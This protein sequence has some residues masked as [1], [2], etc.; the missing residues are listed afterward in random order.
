MN[1]QLEDG[2]V[3][4]KLEKFIL[5]VSIWSCGCSLVAMNEIE[6]VERNLAYFN[7]NIGVVSDSDMDYLINSIKYYVPK[8][9]HKNILLQLNDNVSRSLEYH[10]LKMHKKISS[11]EIIKIIGVGVFS[12]AL[13]VS[14]YYIYH[15]WHKGSNDKFAALCDHLKKMNINISE[16]TECSADFKMNKIVFTLPSSL[17]KEDLDY[18]YSS[19]GTLVELK[20][21]AAKA[22]MIEL[23]LGS[24]LSVFACGAWLGIKAELFSD[25]INDQKKYYEHF[26]LVSKKL[27]QA[28]SKM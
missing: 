20:K 25:D 28:L 13:L 6:M 21:T 12:T 2:V 14:I 1:E 27:E 9:Q 23:F 5:I 17:S 3:L 4:K 10:K 7:N 24:F 26:L 11:K 22:F 15:R 8:A 16:Y 19:M 18:V